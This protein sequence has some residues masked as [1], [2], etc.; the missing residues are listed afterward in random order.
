MSNDDQFLALP[1]NFGGRVAIR[2]NGTNSVFVDGQSN[3]ANGGDEDPRV[4]FIR[5]RGKDYTHSANWQR[6]SGGQWVPVSTGVTQRGSFGMA[7]APRTYAAA[8][9]EMIGDAL[10]RWYDETNGGAAM[11]SAEVQQAQRSAELAA[12]KVVDARAAYEAALEA[13][14]VAEARLLEA[15]VKA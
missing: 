15:R 12:D 13:Q 14:R 8:I 4:C 6:T 7:K 11:R 9:I 3:S 5:Y 1:S 2:P 10:V